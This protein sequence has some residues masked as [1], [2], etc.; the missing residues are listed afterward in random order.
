[1]IFRKIIDLGVNGNLP[2][3]QRREIRMINLF[4]LIIMAGLIVG[5]TS[6]F[7]LGGAYPALTEFCSALIA[8]AII[9]LNA[10]NRYDVATFLF[11]VFINGLIFLINQQYDD[12]VQCYL[13]FF[14]VI[15]CIALI[16]NPD[17]S[18]QRTALFLLIVVC[19]FFSSKLLKIQVLKNTTVTAADNK[20][21]LLYNAY[22]TVIL[23]IFLVYLVVKLINRQNDELI[24][25]LKKEQE[26]QLLISNSLKEKEVLL[27]EIQHRVKNNLAVISGLLNLQ[28]SNAYGNEAKVLLLDAKNRVMSIAMVHDRLY[29]K[30]DLS[31]I[32]LGQY[33][34]ELTDE[35]VG[36]HR[37]NSKIRIIKQI[38]DVDISIT[39]AI[40]TGLIINEVLT[41]SLK[42]AFEHELE[43]PTIQ[44]EMLML[45]GRIWINIFDNGKGFGDLNVR[46]ETSLG[47]SL[48]ESLA[49]QI[50]ADV[51]FTNKGG[52][53]VE[54]SF[55]H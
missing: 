35:V 19:S 55:I 8:I 43:D 40:P 39:K 5:A 34:M 37:L 24:Q 32:N 49:H 6:V 50:D 41:N 26:G 31:K 15:F 7:F 30:Q 3:Y 10:K 47:V 29:K 25:S 13:Y 14:P 45:N 12:S 51:I 11:V 53:F 20:V 16:H 1:M 44:L 33:L 28:L 38:I 48:I 54:L 2:F 23:T 17:R 36:S 46:K 9:V 52:A 22:L 27:A 21:L 4:A 42:H 18:N